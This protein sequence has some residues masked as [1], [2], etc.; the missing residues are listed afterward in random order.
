MQRNV[1]RQ[2]LES[3][4][5]NFT[6]LGKS[7]VTADVTLA[8][9]SHFKTPISYIDILSDSL[10]DSGTMDNRSLFGLI[11]MSL[12]TG[13][14]W[15]SPKGR[16][17]NG[18]V[19]SDNIG[20][21]ISNI[22][23]ITQFKY[24][25]FLEK[26]KLANADI[27]DG[28]IAGDKKV[29]A[30]YVPK[31][32]KVKPARYTEK[33]YHEGTPFFPDILDNAYISDGI[34]NHDKKIT[35]YVKNGY[36]FNNSLAISYRGH[37][38]LRNYSEGG[39]TAHNY[40]WIPSENIKHFFTRLIIANLKDKREK[41]LAYSRH[42]LIT[43]EQ[44]QQTLIIEWSGANDLITVNSPPTFQIADKAIAARRKNILKLAEHGYRN[45]ILF[46]M[47][48]LALTPRFQAMKAAEQ[49]NAENCCDYFNRKLRAMVTELRQTLAL[50]YPNSRVFVF[51]VSQLFND[52]CNN[53]QKYGF[54]PSK[55]KTPFI[56]SPD[57]KI[58]N[59]ISSASGYVFWDDVHPS[60][61]MHQWLMQLFFDQ[62][63]KHFL[64]NMPNREEI[65]KSLRR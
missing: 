4:I 53:P 20:A 32:F 17:T 1:E 14:T 8:S 64:L 30:R 55:L 41:L 22:F 23:T 13:L 36:A 59:G 2:A 47:P 49:D 3:V 50:K 35:K 11:P 33:I 54:D 51:E 40:A 65:E 57:F 26:D 48:N 39:L 18:Y 46:D 43:D 61:D 63:I 37:D 21:K 27:S 62:M 9:S 25:D 10:S 44:K 52:V 7:L 28:L 31:K 56:K 6:L 42:N 15:T 38:F 24:G 5:K 34:I 58:N 19:W 12:I 29:T 45:F 16:F 60:S